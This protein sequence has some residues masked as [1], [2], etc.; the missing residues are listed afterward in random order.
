[1]VCIRTIEFKCKFS[2]TYQTYSQ[3]LSQFDIER[4][5]LF[6]CMTYYIAISHAISLN[7]T[8]YFHM[9]AC[10]KICEEISHNLVLNHYL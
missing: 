10:L 3:V 8:H 7:G 9:K 6:N 4:K 1:M 2:K 5:S